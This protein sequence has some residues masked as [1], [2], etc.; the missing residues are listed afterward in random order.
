ML[1]TLACILIFLFANNFCIGQYFEEK[2][3]IPYTVK[4]GLND[5]YITSLQQDD[6]GYLWIATDLGLNFYDGH[7]MVNYSLLPG[8]GPLLSG[9]IR[10]LKKISP[11]RLGIISLGGVQLLNTKEFSVQNFVIPDSTSF[12]TYLNQSLDAKDLPEGSLAVTTFTGFYV[13]DKMG[14]LSFRH[15]AYKPEDIGKKNIPYG[16]D[17]LSVNDHEYL[18]Y[19][20]VCKTAYYNSKKKLYREIDPS[21][22]EWSF[23]HRSNIDMWVVEYQLSSHELIFVPQNEDK[24]VYYDH[25]TKK[26]VSSSLPFHPDPDLS[27]ESRITPLTDSSFI[28]NG[29]NNGF[30]LFHI[31]RKSGIITCDGK[32]YF[33]EYKVNCLYTDRNQ[34]LWVGTSEGLFQQKLNPPFLKVYSFAPSLLNDT[35]PGSFS[36]AYRYKEKLFVGRYSSK[37]GL[38]IFDTATMKP[39]KNIHFFGIFSAWNEVRSIE[40]YHPDTLWIGTT[41]GLLWLDVKTFK[42]GKITGVSGLPEQSGE[43]NVLSPIDKNGYAWL[44]S[45]LGGVAARYQPATRTF[46]FFTT[47]TKP[48]IPFTRIKQ[49]VYDADGNVWLS[50]HSLARWNSQKQIFDTVMSVYG[51]AKKFYD[52][53]LVIRADKNGSLWLHNA[54]N[55]LL[56][57]DINKKKFIQF[58][59][60]DG[61]F[62]DNLEGMSPVINNTIWIAYRD[63]LVRFDLQTKK[64][65]T[66]DHRDGL[67]VHKPT[68]KYIFYDA[69]NETCYLFCKNDLVKFPFHPTN[70]PD[71][72]SDLFIQKMIIN[73]DKAFYNPGKGISL[74]PRENNLAIHF[75]LID[76]E[77]GDDYTFAYKLNNSDT[78]VNPGEQR[79]ITLTNLPSGKYSL[80]LKAIAKSG[81]E[82]N[83]EFDFS[84]APPFWKTPWFIILVVLLVTG[85]IFSLYRFRVNQINKKANIDRLLAKTEMK[86]LHAQMNPHFVFNSLNSIMEMVLNDDKT[87]ASRY[88]SNYA[89]LI[90]LNLD[91]SQRTFISLRENIDYLHL[92]L[93]LERI[94]TNS[95]ESTMEIADDINPDEILLPPMLIQPFIENAIWYGSPKKNMPMKLDIR[96][97]K[98]NGQLLCII[99]DNGIG[100]EA[101]QKTRSEKIYSH[102]PMG[103]ANV[104]QRIQILNEK[105]KLNCSLVIEDKSKTGS[106][107]ESG[108]KVSLRLPLNLYDL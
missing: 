25:R 94:R 43:L 65:I 104:R 1:R 12:T 99:D 50:G 89:Q 48:A 27:Y 57:Y 47:K 29:G 38:V 7:K 39:I 80:H 92:Y 70:L 18:I 78:W 22:K 52:N 32:R 26:V 60:G 56:Q 51:G 21:E 101:S 79:T 82:K 64:A 85:G 108:T 59:P 34:R 67:P 98:D 54:E 96:F 30:W 46:Q 23:F 73:N 71:R 103:I 88:L 105:Y 58:N 40:M 90:R 31:D 68:S 9:Y 3:F 11:G 100:I 17:I 53:I 4:D 20:D 41:N 55:G 81:I 86:A 91:H 93:E 24:I 49:I 66:Y 35:L 37:T 72:S 76:F 83:K 28:L 44:C 45:F 84:I 107:I 87:N 97:L 95:F 2:D 16:R 75:T 62:S 61:V 13:Y 15:D 36:C 19:F 14:K 10:R 106:L 5:N 42:Y 8:K 69:G 63:K 74:N 6:Q 33:S 77:S 102:T